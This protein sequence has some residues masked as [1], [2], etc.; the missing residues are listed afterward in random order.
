[1]SGLMT[2]AQLSEGASSPCSH[3]SNAN[4]QHES[5]HPSRSQDSSE[6][7][8]PLI[9][10]RLP[11]RSLGANLERLRESIYVRYLMEDFVLSPSRDTESG[12]LA[13]LLPK[14]YAPA[15]SKS[16]LSLAVRA[17]A[18]AY[19]GN[20]RKASELQL[21]ARELYGGCLKALASDLTSLEIATS[22]STSIAVLILGLYEVSQIGDLCIFINSFKTTVDCWE[23]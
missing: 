10:T 20:K 8:T 15:A 19:I 3:D 17:A 22:T 6:P 2:P 9:A 13:L 4:V 12:W 21:E 11:E 23:R 7:A 16:T 5:S 14:L 18:Y 1:M